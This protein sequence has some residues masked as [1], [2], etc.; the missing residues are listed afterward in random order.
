MKR[1]V[2]RKAPWE[3]R[4]CL[5][6]RQE[7]HEATM[8]HMTLINDSLGDLLR[9]LTPWEAAIYRARRD[10]LEERRRLAA[11]RRG[12]CVPWAF[13]LAGWA[14]TPRP[15]LP[16]AR[17]WYGLSILLEYQFILLEPRRREQERQRL[18]SELGWPHD[19]SINLASFGQ[20]EPGPEA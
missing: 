10:I 9:P 14:G 16:T 3:K 1:R 8:E 7:E 2:R 13:P 20:E 12:E 17:R 15:W 6:A 18:N 5:S 19:P 11:I 4:T